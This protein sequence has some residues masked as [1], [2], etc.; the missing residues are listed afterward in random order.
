MSLQKA[1]MADSK[2]LVLGRHLIVDAWFDDTSVIDDKDIEKKLID[3]AEIA[4]FTVLGSGSHKFEPQGVTSFVL[5][6]ESH[7]SIHTWPEHK[8]ATLDIFSCGGDPWVALH[9][10]KDKLKMKRM[11]VKYFE[12]GE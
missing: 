8:C 9:Y 5:L 10:L 3:A 1:S 7:I 2:G 11:N 12:R 6:S 4:G